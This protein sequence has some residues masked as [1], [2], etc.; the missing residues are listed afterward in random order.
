MFVSYDNPNVKRAIVLCDGKRLQKCYAADTDLGV[1]LCLAVN[2]S[3]HCYVNQKTHSFEKV[4][5][6]G[7]IEIF[8]I[9]EDKSC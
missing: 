4:L 9:T 8:N 1:A 3:G 7:K 6:Q 2:E 5:V